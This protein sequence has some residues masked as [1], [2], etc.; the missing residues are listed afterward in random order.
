[1]KKVYVKP[2]VEVAEMEDDLMLITASDHTSTTN[3]LNSPTTDAT[4]APGYQGEIDPTKL[5]AFENPF[6][7]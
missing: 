2:V 1:M 4:D 7:F 5:P 3:F 6:Y